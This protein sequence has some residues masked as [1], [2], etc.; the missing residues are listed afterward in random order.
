MAGSTCVRLAGH[1][2]FFLIRSNAKLSVQ[3]EWNL[4][5]IERIEEPGGG[6]TPLYKPSRDVRPP[7]VWFLSRFGLK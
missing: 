3:I 2:L 4:N 1:E 5:W 7:R 6:G